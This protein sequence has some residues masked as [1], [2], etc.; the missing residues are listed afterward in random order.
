MY[1]RI[2]RHYRKIRGLTQ[3]DLARLVDV[4]PKTISSWEVDRT[5]PDMKAIERLSVALGVTKSELVGEELSFE[6]L[7]A[8]EVDLLLAYRSASKEIRA[9]AEAVLKI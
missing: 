6:K 7:S 2:I 8:N 9:A 5:E 4:S 1:G 3:K